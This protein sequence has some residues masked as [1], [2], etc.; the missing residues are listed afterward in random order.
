MYY[1]GHGTE[2]NGAW[3][4]YLKELS[5]DIDDT[6]IY[7]NDVLDILVKSRYKGNFEISSDSCYSGSLCY[8]A[9]EFYE[10]NGG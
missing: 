10:K 4:V 7:L 9:K 6:K 8:L 5:M 3:A 2:E 1:S